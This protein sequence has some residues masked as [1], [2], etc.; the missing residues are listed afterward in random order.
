MIL[1]F[2]ENF[3]IL[4]QQIHVIPVHSPSRLTSSFVKQRHG[5]VSQAEKGV[6]R[7]R[8]CLIDSNSVF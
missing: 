3:C 4:S 2:T 7:S 8:E 5:H 1:R 6:N